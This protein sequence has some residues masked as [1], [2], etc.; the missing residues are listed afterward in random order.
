MKRPNILFLMADQMQ[1]RVLDPAHPCLTPNFDRLA[2]MGTRFTHAYTPNAVC[3][4]AR[5]SIMTGLLPHNHGVLEVTHCVDKDQCVLRLDK[6]H[7]AQRLAAAGYRTGYFGKWHVEHSEK[8]SSFGWQVDGG[9]HNGLFK[10]RRDD[11]GCARGDFDLCRHIDTPE[12]YAQ[13]LHYAVTNAKP[14]QRPMGVTTSLAS[15]YLDDVCGQGAPW[16]CFVS[17]SEPHDPFV[18]G[19]DAF[20]QYRVDDIPLAPNVGPCAEGLPGIYRKAARVWQG[21]TEREHREAAACY[22]ASITE[23]DALYGRLIDKVESAGELENTITVLTADHGE[24]LGAHGLYCK[25]FSGFEE[26][27]NVPLIV[28]GPGQASGVASDARVGTHDLCPTLLELIGQEP[29]D[30]PDSCPFAAVLR[31]PATASEFTTGFAEYHGSR[32]RI[33][34]RVCWNGPWKYL[35]NGFDFD[36]L[37]NLDDDPYELQNLIDCP[38]HQDILR[39]MAAQMWRKIRDTGDH[40]LYRAKYPI[41]RVAPFGQ[42]VVDE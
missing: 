4:P 6:P 12:G 10:Q 26:I 29:F 34:Q 30:V 17:V 19:R 9:S 16:C 8:P 41:L 15:D 18:A 33:T 40:A 31:D 38:A 32:Y 39:T 1:G 2:A 35:H 22:Y 37:Y 3:S 11:V 21:M 14:E 20:A 42:N 27:Y 7:W 24:L 28:A 23:I 13:G 5:A 25:N 36:E